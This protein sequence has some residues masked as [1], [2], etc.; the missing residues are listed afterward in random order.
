MELPDNLAGVPCY[1]KKK[2]IRF[3][4]DNLCNIY[5]AVNFTTSSTLSL[6]PA[7]F[8]RRVYCSHAGIGRIV[9]IIYKI[10]GILIGNSF[11]ETR[12]RRNIQY[13][14]N[15]FQ[16][17]GQIAAWH[18]KIYRNYLISQSDEVEFLGNI[19]L[20]RSRKQIID[21]YNSTRQLSKLFYKKCRQEQ[22]LSTHLSANFSFD[23]LNRLIELVGQKEKEVSS[24]F[25]NSEN[26]QETKRLVRIIALEGACEE[27]IPFVLLK[28]A[29]RWPLEIL[30]KKEKH[31][32]SLK[33]WSSKLNKERRNL[34]FRVFHK[35]LK[36]LIHHF[37]TYHPSRAASSELINLELALCTVDCKVLTKTD[38][39]HLKWRETLKEG[40]TLL[41]IRLGKQ[42]GKK[43][44]H[45]DKNLL[46]EIQ[47]ENGEIDPD[48]LIKIGPNCA[49][50]ALK[51]KLCEEKLWG[52]LK[53]PSFFSIEPKGRFAIIERLKYPLNSFKW[54]K[55]EKIDK[56]GKKV[57]Y[58]LK[59][60]IEEF[61][62]RGFTPINF[63]KDYLFFT[64]EGE[65][66]SS[67]GFQKGKNFDVMVLE[68]IAYQ[69]ANGKN[70]A[71]YQTLVD[72]L[73]K[74]KENK[75]YIEYFKEIVALAVKGETPRKMLG[76]I[77]GI[78][79]KKVIEQS[80]RLYSDVTKVRKECY[81]Y[82]E[83]HYEVKN[84][85]E[86]KKMFESTFI[87]LYQESKTFGRLWPEITAQAIQ[88][89]LAKRGV[90]DFLLEKKE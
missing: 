76:G 71:V 32:I 17:M 22:G 3:L 49:S 2:E 6:V 14:D 25:Y 36:S 13:L 27:E 33:Q 59:E 55:E 1:F 54:E 65:I 58:A 75:I 34:D 70:L 15:Y 77:Y 89:K 9:H 5:E 38:E 87:K 60:L 53:I 26:Y 78:K 57:I 16:K 39:K 45:F 46:F 64:K 72:P 66:A 56:Q 8:G 86:F 63:S 61:L 74:F 67:K 85:N 47:N 12:L 24:L 4:E 10:I 90:K 18:E 79:D 28:N 37:Q 73:L 43:T 23:H 52:I 68:E 81:Q 42:I 84:L 19:D 20:H 51:A 35:G 40:D 29:S 88:E 30:H 11:K 83:A 50:L 41:G 69:F 31:L 21:F 7:L 48:R 80:E 62:N 82:I 44:I